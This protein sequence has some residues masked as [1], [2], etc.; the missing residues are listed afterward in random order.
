MSETKNLGTCYKIDARQ[1]GFIVQ[2]F[3]TGLLSFVGHNPTFAVTRY[4][5][6]I[7]FADG[8][9]EVESMLVM[10]QTETI[11]LLDEMNEKDTA[12]IENTMHGEV[13]ETKQF[14]EITFVSKDISLKQIS[15][16]R[17]AVT[18]N[19]NLSL[20][21]ETR[22]QT[23]EAEAEI[24]DGKIRAEGEFTLSQSNFSIKQ[25]KAL[26]GTL[27]VK[28]EVKISFDIRAEV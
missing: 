23:I 25:T 12:E 10:I 6:E 3:A 19:G 7:Q 16:G 9:A 17:F 18:A 15:N 21:G 14:P 20:H 4:G 13:L 28:D 8:N 27:K 24:K 22:P 1:S 11:S 2:A 5:G 26:G